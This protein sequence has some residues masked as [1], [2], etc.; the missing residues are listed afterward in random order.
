MHDGVESEREGTVGGIE[1]AH[2][3]QNHH[4]QQKGNSNVYEY[5][6]SPS[7]SKSP[8]DTSSSI[9]SPST[10]TMTQTIKSGSQSSLRSGISLK[11]SNIHPLAKET[12]FDRNI[13]MDPDPKSGNL[14][15]KQE[16]KT[17]LGRDY[18]NTPSD[19]LSKSNVFPVPT[20][21][22]N[23][24]TSRTQLVEGVPQTSV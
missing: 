6:D 1:N 3:I 23:L 21:R 2:M 12:N 22:K 16:E 14:G 9:R 8:T 17:L 18:P 24:K 15:S 4:A 20:A 7:K 5:H 10:L 19:S 13:K 11:E